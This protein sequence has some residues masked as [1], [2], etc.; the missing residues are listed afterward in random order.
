MS[1]HPT[2]ASPGILTSLRALGDGLLVS[3]H[4]R[5]ELISLELQEEKVRLMQV[6]LWIAAAVFSAAMAITFAS[7]AVVYFFWETARL[8]VILGL[9]IF[10]AVAFAGVVFGFRRYLARQ[11]RPFAGTLQELQED[12]ACFRKES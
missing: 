2:P 9:G 1:D 3:A 7:L 4:N 12:S 6:F 11:P 10:Y 5:I 8:G